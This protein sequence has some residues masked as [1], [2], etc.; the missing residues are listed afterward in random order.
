M[1]TTE[2]SSQPTPA[3]FPVTWADPADEQLAWFQDN[4][5]FPLAQTP[6]NATMV[7]TAFSVG[8][9]RAISKLSMPIEGLKTAVH[10][11]YLYLAPIPVLGEPSEIEARFE[12]MK[13]IT[14]ELGATV[15]RD[16]RETFEPDVLA[17]G[18]RIL[19]F[20]YDGSSTSEVAAFVHTFYDELVDVW[21]IHMRVNIP[22]M[23]AVFG[24][25]EFLGEVLGEDAIA[26]SRLLLQGFENKSIELG[27]ALWEL[28]RWVRSV[29][30]LA[31]A[32]AN[33][34]VRDGEVQLGD[35][36]SADEFQ[37]RLR[38]FLDVYGWRSDVF[39]EVGSQSWQE[40][41]STP[42]SLLR[43]YL[44]KDDADDPFVAHAQQ[45]QDR[46]RLVE[47][48]A[49]RLPEQ[50]QPQ[51]HGMLVI[52]QQYI[53]IAEDHNFTIDQKFQSIVRHGV[54]QLGGKLVADGLLS[55]PEDACYLTLEEIGALGGG[56]DGSALAGTVRERRQEL[57]RQRSLK[58]PPMLGTPSPEDA[59]PDPL[60]TK[61]FGFGVVQ[62]GDPKVI[63]GYPASSGV[64]TGEA[65]VVMTL[66]EAGKIE[67]GDILVCQ[68]TMPAWTPLFGIVAAVVSDSGGPLSHCAIVA[69]EYQ[70][71]CVAGTQVGTSLIRDGMRIRVDG[72]TGVV[73]ILD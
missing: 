55:D 45:A 53:P 49:A 11:G 20:D 62:S 46:D 48:M 21:D 27:R 33:A 13:R 56:A 69:R 1:T 70:I 57:L 10:N 5:H 71:P 38:A 58:P 50:L 19:S 59:P 8:A 67:P 23:N 22:P 12:E 26:Q 18:E 4:L 24:L 9:S 34:R 44:R 17:R 66:D 37:E 32:V 65:K 28:S 3:D 40:D 51:F 64:V 14:M 15:L 2:G 68:M 36:A 61:F 41:P 43:G 73:Q 6:L 72:T 7:Q 47:E 39:A 25:E 16:W 29:D 54:L 42:L 60:V 63:S 30:G 35:H 52:A 31:E